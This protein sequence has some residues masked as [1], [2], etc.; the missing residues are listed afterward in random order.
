MTRARPRLLTR[1]ALAAP[2]LGRSTAHACG[3]PSAQV[4]SRMPISSQAMNSY[5]PGREDA[6]LNWLQPLPPAL[7]HGGD[8][9]RRRWGVPG[10]LRRPVLAAA[11]GRLPADRRLASSRRVGPGRHG[12][13]LRRLGA[14]AA[15]RPGSSVR[16][17][18]PAQPLPLAGTPD[19]GGDLAPARQPA[20]GS[21]PLRAGLQWR[22]PAAVG[23]AAAA[24]RQ[25][26][27]VVLRFYLDLSEAEV[28]RLL[29][30][31]Q[32]TVKSWTHRGLARL[33]TRLSTQFGDDQLPHGRK[34]RQ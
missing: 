30:V 13:H 28:A 29:G 9:G 33:R 21:G 10:L 24:S 31:P 18:G 11:T 14:A 12:A 6:G 19:A 26:S 22:W 5:E 1:N 16:P 25:R 17:Q 20:R 34:A 23:G 2:K 32:G 7:R 8:H 27:A 4:A 15:S 3:A